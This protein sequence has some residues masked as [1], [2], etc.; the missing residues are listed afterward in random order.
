M[1]ELDSVDVTNHTPLVLVRWRDAA[2][3]EGWYTMEEARAVHPRLVETVGFL[4]GVEPTHILLAD[5][6]IHCDEH[7][8][9]PDCGGPLAIPRS[10]IEGIEALGVVEDDEDGE[11]CWADGCDC[12]SVGDMVEC[13]NEKCNATGKVFTQFYEEA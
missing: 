9:G 3:A 10:E 13:T 6:L 1:I 2:G 12:V 7:D 4:I 5:S 8:E 11:G